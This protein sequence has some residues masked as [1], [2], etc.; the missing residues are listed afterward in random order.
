MNGDGV[1]NV[2]DL[3]QV[4]GALGGDGAAPSAYS[5]D[6]SIISAADVE[7]WLAGAQ[8]IGVGDANFQRGIRFLEQFACGVDAER[9]D[10]VA[11]LPEPL[12]SGDMDTVPPRAGGGG[13]DYDLRHEGNAGAA[14]GARES[15]DAGQYA[16]R[17][18]AAYWDGQNKRRGSGCKRDLHL[19]IP[20]GGLCGVA[21][22]GDC[23]VESTD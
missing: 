4:A 9:D 7:R 15:G 11:E 2:F 16:E 10:A 12:Q 13:G 1:V 21:T 22:D 6:P 17:G 8:G 20:G 3:V 14:V 19:S 23:E 5:L 18:K